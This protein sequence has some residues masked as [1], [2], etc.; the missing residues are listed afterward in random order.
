MQ[1]EEDESTSPEK[2]MAYWQIFRNS[3]TD[4]P[5]TEPGP[6]QWEAGNSPPKPWHGR[7]H[8]LSP[9]PAIYI[10]RY[11]LIFLIIR[12]IGLSGVPVT[13]NSRCWIAN[14]VQPSNLRLDGVNKAVSLV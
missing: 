3:D 4:W 12:D 7:F 14:A 2:N 10:Y 5:H 13:R 8:T 6:P 9:C 11:Q 1:I